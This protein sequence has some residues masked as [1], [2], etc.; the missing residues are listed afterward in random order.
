[1]EET[2]SLIGGPICCSVFHDLMSRAGL[3]RK[4]IISVN[5]EREVYTL[6]MLPVQQRTNAPVTHSQQGAN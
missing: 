2:V 1:M 3:P 4:K 5:H 6:D